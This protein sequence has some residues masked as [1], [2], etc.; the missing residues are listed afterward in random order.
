MEK[1]CELIGMLRH[2]NF[3]RTIKD[4]YVTGFS[5]NIDELNTAFATGLK[6][7]K[8]KTCKSTQTDQFDPIPRPTSPSVVDFN[9]LSKFSN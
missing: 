9:I 2:L 8:R 6:R 7:Q 5:F 3:E 4:G 1:K